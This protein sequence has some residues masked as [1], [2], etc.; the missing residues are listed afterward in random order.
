ME[1]GL[2]RAPRAADCWKTF[3]QHVWD[4]WARVAQAG[5]GRGV[6]AVTPALRFDE[7]S[8]VGE[9]ALGGDFVRGHDPMATSGEVE[10]LFDRS[11]R[12]GVLIGEPPAVLVLGVQRLGLDQDQDENFVLR[13]TWYK[14][15]LVV[16][17][18]ASSAGTPT[19]FALRQESDS[20]IGQNSWL[21]N[22]PI[23][24]VQLGLC[25]EL[26]ILSPRGRSLISFVDAALRSFAEDAWSE[27]Y[28]SLR[29]E[30]ADASGR[31][32]PFTQPSRGADVQITA[33]HADAVRTILRQGRAD[34]L[35]WYLELEQWRKDVDSRSVCAPE[36]FDIFAEEL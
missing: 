23:H 3:E 25:D 1:G 30:L 13:T 26:R 8:L 27:M 17:G 12:S 2:I 35:D 6:I 7:S 34:R 20:R 33:S 32:A 22:H 28:P 4:Y 9:V 19:W 16:R 21:L 5:S 15:C 18:T 31:F 11:Y 24:H 10:E 36:M 14:Y 29:L